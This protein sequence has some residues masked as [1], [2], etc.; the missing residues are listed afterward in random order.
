MLK[1]RS[2]DEFRTETFKVEIILDLLLR[3]IFR[4]GFIFCKHRE[5]GAIR[6]F[7]NLRSRC[8]NATCVRNTI[9]VVQYTVHMQAGSLI[10]PSENEC[11]K[12]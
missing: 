1:F 6:E 3:H 12:Y 4:R 8:M 10:L 2:Q 5:L 7:N 9:V 11:D